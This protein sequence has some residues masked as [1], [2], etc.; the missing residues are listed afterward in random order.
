MNI[1]TRYQPGEIEN[2]ED[3]WKISRYS[4]PELVLSHRII[5]KRSDI[6]SVGAILFELITGRKL[7]SINLYDNDG[8]INPLLQHRMIRNLHAIPSDVDLELSRF[9]D[10]FNKTLHH[11]HEMRYQT[12]GELLDIIADE[13]DDLNSN[14]VDADL[15]NYIRKTVIKMSRTHHQQDNR[16]DMKDVTHIA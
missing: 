1:G 3:I 6:Y 12:A 11:Q 5:D 14:L 16:I 2:Q 15:H 7:I 13:L 8:N 4:A 10:L 9:D